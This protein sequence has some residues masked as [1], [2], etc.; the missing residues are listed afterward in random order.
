MSPGSA[1]GFSPDSLSWL[2]GFEEQQL[3]V[4]DNPTE[5]LSGAQDIKKIVLA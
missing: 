3:H 2:A 5:I 4:F 1:L